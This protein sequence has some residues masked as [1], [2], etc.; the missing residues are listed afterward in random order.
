MN[1]E[2]CSTKLCEMHVN[3]FRDIEHDIASACSNHP[4]TVNDL[5]LSIENASVEV[6]ASSEYTK[7]ATHVYLTRSWDCMRPLCRRK[8]VICDKNTGK[9][10]GVIELVVILLHYTGTFENRASK[11]K[12]RNCLYFVSKETVTH[13]QLCDAIVLKSWC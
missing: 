1:E 13:F 8:V 7:H 12:F 10:Q 11:P 3:W 5:H 9:V 2:I 4:F 6:P